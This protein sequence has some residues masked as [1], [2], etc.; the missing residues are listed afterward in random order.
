[1]SAA[2]APKSPQIFFDKRNGRPRLARV[3]GPH[4]FADW[5][6][7]ERTTQKKFQLIEGEYVEMAGASHEHNLIAFD[8][9]RTLADAL[10]AAETGCELVGS[11]QKIYVR[12]KVGY[13][14]DVVVF[15]SEA[16]IDFEEGLRNPTVLVEILSESTAAFDR[17]TKFSDYR[18]LPSF[19]HYVLIEQDRV[20]VEH[21]AKG[22]DNLWT[23]VGE[24]TA[25]TDFLT[26]TL[27]GATVTVSLAKIYRRVA[28]K[29][30]DATTQ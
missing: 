15:C 28:P 24:H 22:D 11:D 21:F 12:H 13:Y 19:A 3:S 16:Q 18:T 9:A 17:G 30:P 10:D 23:L 5:V 29:A 1:M 26:L 25:L 4:T 20:S 6:A 8:F 7:F 14:P 27:G 2:A